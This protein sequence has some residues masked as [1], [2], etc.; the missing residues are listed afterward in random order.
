MNA[1]KI[2]RLNKTGEYALVELTLR[3]SRRIPIN[4]NVRLSL[5]RRSMYLSLDGDVTQLP[6][7]Q[8][9]SG[10]HPLAQ[11]ALCQQ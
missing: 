11:F 9:S 5:P 7:A 4:V 3:E 2:P 6:P 10:G 8:S 1:M